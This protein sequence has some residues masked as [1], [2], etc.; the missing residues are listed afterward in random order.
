MTILTVTIHASPVVIVDPDTN[1]STLNVKHPANLTLLAEET[2]IAPKKALVYVNVPH[3]INV[4]RV[5]FAIE[6]EVVNILV[7]MIWIVMSLNIATKT[8]RF[9]YLD[10]KKTSFA[11]RI[12]VNNKQ[13]LQCV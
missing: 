13:K 10:G 6:M 7:W 2:N 8:K 12:I 9:V 11:N 1:V 4:V 3:S 5:T